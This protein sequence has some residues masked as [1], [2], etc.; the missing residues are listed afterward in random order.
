MRSA[1]RA[2]AR[3]PRRVALGLRL[4]VRRRTGARVQL[5][6]FRTHKCV[7]SPLSLS[8]V[9]V[10]SHLPVTSGSISSRPEV[11]LSDPVSV[12]SLRSRPVLSARAL[13][14]QL[15]ASPCTLTADTADYSVDVKGLDAASTYSVLLIAASEARLTYVFERLVPLLSSSPAEP[16]T[17]AQIS[18]CSQLKQVLSATT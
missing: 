9:L 1:R 6:L 4:R 8:L 7:C 5:E 14:G 2:R 17:S 12:P 18:E 11:L 3:G 16:A 10:P 13:C 15:F